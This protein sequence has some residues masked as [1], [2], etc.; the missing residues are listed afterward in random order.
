MKKVLIGAIFGVLAGIGIYTY[1]RTR[2]EESVENDVGDFDIEF[3]VD[4]TNDVVKE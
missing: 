2:A 4:N 1:A 3:Y